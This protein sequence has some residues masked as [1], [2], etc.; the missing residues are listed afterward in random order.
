MLLSRHIW[1]HDSHFREVPLFVL[2]RDCLYCDV[3]TSVQDYK[4]RRL[5]SWVVRS[6]SSAR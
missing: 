1:P 6:R 5:Y 4:K 3:P 2:D